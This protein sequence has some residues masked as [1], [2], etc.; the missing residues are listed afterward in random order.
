MYPSAC[1]DCSDDDREVSRRAEREREEW[2]PGGGGGGGGKGMVEWC[3]NGAEVQK[4]E[5]VIIFLGIENLGIFIFW[6]WDLGGEY[7][8]WGVRFWALGCVHT[9]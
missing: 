4:S 8:E 5:G 3:L 7:G 2:R 6:I 9:L 1:R